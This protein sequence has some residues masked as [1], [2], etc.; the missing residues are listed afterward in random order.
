MGLQDAARHLLPGQQPEKNL[1][2]IFETARLKAPSIIF[3]DEVEALGG[4]REKIGQHFGRALTNQFLMEMDGMQSDNSDV[5]TIGATNSLWFV[6]PA[7]RRPGRFDRVILVPPPDIDARI[8]ILKLHLKG[9]PWEDIDYLKAAKLME[10][11]SGADIKNVCDTAR[12]Y[13]LK[14]AMATGK[15]IP[16]TTADL[17]NVL[18]QVKSSTIEWLTTAKTTP[19]T[20]TMEACTIRL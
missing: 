20:A 15:I 13:I 12:E 16:F 3:V 2:S 18:K 11:Y 5:L 10:H 14:K 7:L 8:E 6:D 9:K 19:P 4:S 1:H 17:L